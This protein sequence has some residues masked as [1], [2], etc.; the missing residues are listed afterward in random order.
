MP[1]FLYGSFWPD[2]CACIQFVCQME[3]WYPCHRAICTHF[4]NE[5]VL[6]NADKIG[7][8]VCVSLI[9][10]QEW[11][12]SLRN[13][14]SL[15]LLLLLSLFTLLAFS[16]HAHRTESIV[17]LMKKDNRHYVCIAVV[18]LWLAL[19]FLPKNQTIHSHNISIS[20]LRPN[21]ALHALLWCA[22]WYPPTAKM[23]MHH[24]LHTRPHQQSMR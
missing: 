14:F 8:C 23:M 16:S 4:V 7:V 5:N 10:M 19:L 22:V 11:I 2:M 9:E 20:I 18:G 21:I 17:Q 1:Y 6:I 3:K 13:A 24:T 12:K 15:L